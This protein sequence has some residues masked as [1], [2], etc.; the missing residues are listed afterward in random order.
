MAAS[1]PGGCGS[2]EPAAGGQASDATAEPKP[3]SKLVVDPTGDYADS[4]ALPVDARVKMAMKDLAFKPNHVTARQGQTIV[5]VN[6][7]DVDHQIRGSF[8]LSVKSKVLK[9]G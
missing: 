4:T 1:R 9:P 2:D 5:F 6:E 8:A 7:D 3:S